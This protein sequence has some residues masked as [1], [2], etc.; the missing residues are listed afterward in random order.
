LLNLKINKLTLHVTADSDFMNM[1]ISVGF[2]ETPATLP[3]SCPQPESLHYW[4][5]EPEILRLGSKTK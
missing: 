4:Q 5:P 3:N 1:G 2:E